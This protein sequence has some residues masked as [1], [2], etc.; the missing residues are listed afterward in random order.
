MGH[1]KFYLCRRQRDFVNRLAVALAQFDEAQFLWRF[2]VLSPPVQLR[3][4]PSC[5]ENSRR[6]EAGGEVDSEAPD[7]GKMMM[8]RRMIKK[9]RQ[10][11][12]H[13]IQSRPV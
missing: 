6:S 11:E 13:I 2:R 12:A 8:R 5:E 10:C 9:L 1:Q 3:R 4:K 7:F